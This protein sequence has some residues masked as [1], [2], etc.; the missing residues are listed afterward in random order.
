MHLRK[1]KISRVL[2]IRHNLNNVFILRCYVNTKSVANEYLDV[3]VSL[4][5]NNE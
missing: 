5:T 4:L 1:L 2:Q 3:V